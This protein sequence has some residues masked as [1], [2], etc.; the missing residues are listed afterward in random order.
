MGRVSIQKT[1]ILKRR[2]E[3]ERAGNIPEWG[4]T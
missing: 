4:E 1:E 3:K 2:A